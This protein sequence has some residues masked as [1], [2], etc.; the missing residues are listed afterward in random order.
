MRRSTLWRVPLYSIAV[1]YVCFYLVVYLLGRF[2]FIREAGSTS[3]DP[4]RSLLMYALIFIVVV[5]GGGLVLFRQMTR[6]EVFWSATIMVVLYAVLLAVQQRFPVVTVSLAPIYEW[7]HFLF[8]LVYRST[9][10]FWLGIV[11]QCLAPYCFVLFGQR[12][13]SE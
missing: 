5:A 13:K 1:G 3:V 6:R 10:L 8:Q 4:M 9:G 2:A 11:L 7:T 12:A